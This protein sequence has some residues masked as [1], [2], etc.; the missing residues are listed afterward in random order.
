MGS[1]LGLQVYTPHSPR[2][3]ASPFDGNFLMRNAVLIL[4]GVCP[5]AQNQGQHESLRLAFPEPLGSRRPHGPTQPQLPASPW[6]RPP[7][8]FLACNLQAGFQPHPTR[9]SKG[10]AVRVSYLLPVCGLH[11]HLPETH[12]LGEWKPG[13]TWSHA[14][15]EVGA[16]GPRAVTKRQSRGSADGRGRGCSFLVMR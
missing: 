6:L 12:L 16:Q 2:T 14:S 9:L 11:F 15:P 13:R 10:E 5:A 8:L 1:E 3:L 4:L 7:P